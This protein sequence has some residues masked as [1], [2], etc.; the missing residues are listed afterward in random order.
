MPMRALSIF[1]LVLV[2]GAAGE[3]PQPI[4]A[5]AVWA[6]PANFL[7]AFHK[8]CD[9]REGAAFTDCFRDAMRQADASP[10]AVAFAGR[11]DGM[12]Y[13]RAF[14]ETGR[15]D[16]AFADFPFRANENRLC[17]LVNGQPPL[18][19]VDD[20]SRLDR[21]ALAANRDYA[22]LSRA[23]PHVAIFPGRRSN[24]RGP[25]AVRLR[26]GGQGFVVP[27]A[28]RDGCHACKIV[29]DAKLRFDF[30][31]EGRFVGIAVDRV[32]RRS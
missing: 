3:T 14:E 30:D 20:L 2:Q 11:V 24:P 21:E 25:A 7:E 17:F 16:L 31:V 32:R 15:V 27:Y 13:L 23:Y 9:G 4:G 1:A 6:P 5:D 22:E 29:G 12:G 18:I 8:T 28:L 19:D 26:N 10:A